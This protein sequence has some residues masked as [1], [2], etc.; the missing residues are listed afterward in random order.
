MLLLTLE[1]F[2]SSTLHLMHPALPNFH[3]AGQILRYILENTLIYTI[4]IYKLSFNYHVYNDG[5]MD[6]TQ[7]ALT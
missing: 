5:R 3:F 4:V 2:P 6:L 1:R 7:W